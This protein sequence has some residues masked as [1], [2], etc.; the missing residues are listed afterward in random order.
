[1]LGE[2]KGLRNEIMCYNI[3]EYIKNSKNNQYELCI[4]LDCAVVRHQSSMF[5][6]PAT[7]RSQVCYASGRVSGAWGWVG[8]CVANERAIFYP[9]MYYLY[10]YWALLTYF[11]HLLITYCRE[12]WVVVVGLLPS[13][14]NTS[15]GWLA[16][17]DAD[18]REG[19][20]CDTIRPLPIYTAGKSEKAIPS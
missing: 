7:V 3:N 1:M 20:A 11:L 10:Y 8:E 9:F 4:Y 16:G 19:R 2:Y 14:H 12:A 6:L 17:W 5:M 18:S 15:T 13:A